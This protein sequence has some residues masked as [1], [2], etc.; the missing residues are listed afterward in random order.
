MDKSPKISA[1]ALGKLLQ[2]RAPA[3][4]EQI[5]A[6]INAAPEG[7][8]IAGSEER[9]R[10]VGQAFV[11]AAFEAALQEKVAAAEAAFSPSAGL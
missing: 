1:E 11:K 2:E 6:A 7:S 10:E 9:V 8:W 3:L 4:A 5:V